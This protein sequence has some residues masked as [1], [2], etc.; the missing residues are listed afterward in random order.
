MCWFRNLLLGFLLAGCG[1][2]HPHP[3]QTPTRAPA[4][5]RVVAGPAWTCITDT[6]GHT[7]CVGQSGRSEIAGLSAVA[8]TRDRCC[9]A[10]QG[11]V[12]CWPAERAWLP[13]STQELQPLPAVSI[14]AAVRAVAPSGAG[15]C[16]VTDGGRVVC[17]DSGGS[18]RSPR[19]RGGVSALGASPGHVCALERGG[20]VLCWGEN[21][22]RFGDG[23]VADAPYPVPALLPHAV[24]LS[25]GEHSC[26][27]DESGGVWCWGQNHRGQLGRGWTSAPA[28]EATPGRAELPVAAR[29]VTVG[30]DF[31]CALDARGD[32][33]CWGANDN[34]R[35]GVTRPR[36]VTAPRRVTHLDNARGVSAG[37]THACA[38]NAT[39]VVC[40]GERHGAPMERVQWLSDAP[41]LHL[42]PP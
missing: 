28:F 30:R 31:T 33:Y 2:T 19:L 3:A 42:E 21:R 36:V 34:G 14:G 11:G 27:V 5:A 38:W 40:W 4:I 13:A 35:C 25:V 26:A 16:A 1:A 29:E 41:T 15:G 7:E 18:Q 23:G 6:A 22:G 20:A 10:A 32:V 37:W 17:W 12:R 8:C 39:E 9:V 24:G